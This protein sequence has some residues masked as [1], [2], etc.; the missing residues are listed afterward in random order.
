MTA[1]V[2]LVQW[3]TSGGSHTWDTSDVNMPSTILEVLQALPHHMRLGVMPDAAFQ[4]RL[5]CLQ[6]CWQARVRQALH[7]DALHQGPAVIV[8]DEAH[9]LQAMSPLSYQSQILKPQNLKCN[10]CK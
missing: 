4:C 2:T 1:D 6:H 3:P 7:Y 9:P 10:C 5:L 8:F